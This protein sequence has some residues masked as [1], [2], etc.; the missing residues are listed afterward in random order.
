MTLLVVSPHADDAI[1]SCA[2][3]ILARTRRGERVVVASVFTGG[4]GAGRADE[5]RRALARVGAARV[6]LGFLDAPAREGVAETFGALVVTSRV[7]AATV[8]AVARALAR[9]VLSERV[10]EIWL[11]LGVGGHVD[12]LTVFAARSVMRPAVRTRF[13]LERPYA[14]VPA[15]LA[16]R[17]LQL[18]GGALTRP[19]PAATIARQLAAGGCGAFVV[20]PADLAALARQLATRHAGVGF[21]WRPRHVLAASDPTS[22]IAAYRSQLRWLGVPASRFAGAAERFS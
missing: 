6:D 11:P 18:A 21:R 19:P 1:F 20:T 14:W 17:K 3:G 10:R 7:R 8:R 2:G 22:A 4:A 13:Y 5:D 9:V 15:L 16:L 12:H